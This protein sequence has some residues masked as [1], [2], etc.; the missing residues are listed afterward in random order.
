MV[1][2]SVMEQAAKAWTLPYHFVIYGLDCRETNPTLI[3]P[4][5]VFYNTR[6]GV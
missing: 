5:V 1:Q 6:L 3:F 4:V 2:L